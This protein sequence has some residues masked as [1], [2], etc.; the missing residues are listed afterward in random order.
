L[1]TKKFVREERV[2]KKRE[3]MVRRAA[4]DVDVSTRLA[5]SWHTTYYC[6]SVVSLSYYPC[7]AKL[8]AWPLDSTV[9]IACQIEMGKTV[10]WRLHFNFSHIR[11]RPKF[12]HAV[13]KIR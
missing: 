3:L 9:F 12:L 5:L 4:V 1:E 7:E 8:I 2:V 13:V 11:A 10:D 6:A